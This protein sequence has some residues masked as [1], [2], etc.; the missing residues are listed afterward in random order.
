MQRRYI[1]L[2]AAE[3]TTLEAGRHHHPQH[4]FRARCQGLLWSAD[5]HSVPALAALLDVSQGTVYGWFNRWE[6]GGL[7]GLANAKG[8]GRHAI[9]QAPDRAQVEAAVRANRQQL[10]DVTAKLNQELARS[11]CPLTLKRFLKRVGATGGAS[12][13]A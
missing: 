5:G 1:S 7:A 10:K 6:R 12:A 2:D 9:L 13:T 4:Q 3:R 11:F 8:Q